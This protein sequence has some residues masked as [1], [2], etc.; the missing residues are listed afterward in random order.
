MMMIFFLFTVL[1]YECE[2][3]DLELHIAPKISVTFTSQLP[4]L[5]GFSNLL[6]DTCFKIHAKLSGV[7]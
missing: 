4:F 2:I 3:F 6:Y 5:T 7:G 1:T